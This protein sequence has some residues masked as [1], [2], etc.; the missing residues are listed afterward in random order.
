MDLVSDLERENSLEGKRDG[1]ARKQ[2]ISCNFF[3]G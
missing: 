2:G 3:G 1:R